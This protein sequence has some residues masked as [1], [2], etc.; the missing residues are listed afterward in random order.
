M[1]AIVLIGGQGT[2]L[3]PL[4]YATPKVGLP[5][6][7]RAFL[8]HMLGWFA[9]NGVSQVVFTVHN[10]EREIRQSL[11]KLAPS[12]L[13]IVVRSETQPLGSGGALKNC[14]DLVADQ[15]ML[16]NGDI[17]TDL[18]LADLYRSHQTKRAVITVAV[19]PVDDPS[20]YGIIDMGPDG[21][22]REWQE[23]PPRSAAKSN[24]ANVGGWVMS[25]QV[26]DLIPEGRFVSLEKEIFP[27]ALARGVAF[28]AY[29]FD[30]YWKDIGTVDKYVD[31]NLDLMAGRVR[32]YAADFDPSID[33]R[34]VS[35]QVLVGKGCDIHPSAVIEGPTT[36]GEGVIIGKNATIVGS[37]IWSGSRIGEGA[38]IVKSV[39]AGA[40]IGAGAVLGEECVIA[41]G[42]VVGAGLALAPKTALGPRSILPSE[43]G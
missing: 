4:T 36:I 27:A 6:A 9:R 42:S 5:I 8:E 14:A 37:L 20:H 1:Q 43:A 31:A 34:N 35:G 2:R 32:G 3:Y 12:S 7:N 25:K 40:E 38:R 10:L 17:L 13:D 16:L 41:Q 15:F 11:E 19:A 24:L 21:A 26:L 33:P 22:V 18:D 29:K 23:K 30:G 28:F 39:I